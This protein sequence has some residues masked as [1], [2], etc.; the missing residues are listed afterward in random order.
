MKS[1]N[2]WKLWKDNW[3]NAYRF[4]NSKGNVQTRGKLKQK[5]HDDFM[6]M[7]KELEYIE[8]PVIC[9]QC[10]SDCM[11]TERCSECVATMLDS[12]DRKIARLQERLNTRKQSKES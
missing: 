10:K 2:V 3:D 5:W 12:K 7:F 1:I 8:E 4:F 9:I 11:G 6:K